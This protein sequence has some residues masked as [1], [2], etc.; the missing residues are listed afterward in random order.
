MEKPNT[1]SHTSWL[2]TSNKDKKNLAAHFHTVFSCALRYLWSFS[3]AAS[4]ILKMKFEN[5]LAD[6]N[7]FG[8]FQ[9]RTA[10]L[11]VLPRLTLPFNFLLNNFIAAIPP[12][13]CNISSLDDGGVFSNLSLEER[14]VVSIPVKQDGTSNS[15]KMFTEPQYHLLFNTSNITDLPT[16]PCQNGWVYDNTTFKSTLATQVSSFIPFHWFPRMKSTQ[17]H[18]SYF[19]LHCSSIVCLSLLVGSGLWKEES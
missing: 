8:R 19:Y 11:L 17:S 5:V 15:C 14:L 9:L 12:H 7:G 16:V 3:Q 1:L 4:F 6:V 18:I 10:A 13:H 2:S